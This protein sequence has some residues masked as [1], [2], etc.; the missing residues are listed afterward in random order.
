MKFRVLR[1]AQASKRVV[2]SVIEYAQ[3]RRFARPRLVA[4][5]YHLH[6]H[7]VARMEVVRKT[8][9]QRRGQKFDAVQRLQIDA[10]TVAGQ[11]AAGRA[12]GAAIVGALIAAVWSDSHEQ[13]DHDDQQRFAH[14]GVPERAVCLNWGG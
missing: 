3:R 7:I 5:I 14:F 10:R 4:G 9:D 11:T 1:L 13:Q 2:A 12:L 8:V 6:V